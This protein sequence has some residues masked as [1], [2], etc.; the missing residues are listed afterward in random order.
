[1]F[2]VWGKTK[3]IVGDLETFFDTIQGAGLLFQEAVKDYFNGELERFEQRVDHI[4]TAEAKT[5]ELR[6]TIKK[7]IYTNMLLP[8]SRGDVLAIV[9]TIDDV[10]DEIK[11]I[12][13]SFAI[14]K[15]DVPEELRGDFIQIAEQSKMCIIELIGA[16]R[17][18]FN[19]I[20]EANAYIGRVNFYE[21]EVDVLSERIKRKVYAE[22]S[23][24]SL[25]EKNNLRYFVDMMERITNIAQAVCDRLSVFVIKRSI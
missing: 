20:T 24:Y 22:G 2:G 21:H 13:K 3:L 1:M 25:A 23:T 8:D 6:R 14:E 7:Q 5:D 18:F 16:C 17:S 19:N 10:T 9:E 11:F 12:V 4:D 15:P